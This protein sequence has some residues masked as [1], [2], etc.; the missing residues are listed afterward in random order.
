MLALVHSLRKNRRLLTDLV[1]RDLRARYVGSSMGFFWSVIVPIVLLLV[2]FFVFTTVLKQRWADQQ[3][4]S[5]I[6][7]L[8]LA[9]I[10]IWQAFAESVSRMTNALVE[11]QNLIQK[12]VFPS[13]VLPVYLTVSALVN[14]LLGLVVALCGVVYVGYVRAPS[15]V[16]AGPLEALWSD[17]GG[18]RPAAGN[19]LFFASTLRCATKYAEVEGLTVSDTSAAPWALAL[20]GH[21]AG[22]SELGAPDDHVYLDDHTWGIVR[23]RIGDKFTVD[24][25]RPVELAEHP[26]GAARPAVVDFAAA[27]ASPGNSPTANSP[28]ANSPSVN[29]RTSAGA[30]RAVV[31]RAPSR[32]LV[33]TAWLVALV[34][35]VLLQGVFMLGVGYLLSVFNLFLRDTY[36]VIGVAL[37]VWMFATPIFYPANLVAKA[38][39]AWVLTANPMFWLIESYREVLVYG[40]PPNWMDVGRFA[41]VAFALVFLGAKFFMT[42]KPRFPDL[43]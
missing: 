34:P 41:L 17:A 20:R 6:A 16:A 39:F 18:T 19:G 43:L 21:A 42:Q 35:L 29:S 37:L 26:R 3:G 10:L 33:V 7:L 27:N 32:P 28:S 31:V 8:M 23:T 25:W 15:D 36:H 14:M 11:N 4:K 5:E 24:R 40:S 9:G 13:E 30:R 22:A 2:Y 38:G 12:V 1:S